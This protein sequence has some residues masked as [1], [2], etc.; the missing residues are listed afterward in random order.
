MHNWQSRRDES[1]QERIKSLKETMFP[2]GKRRVG[3]FHVQARMF[4][5]C[6]F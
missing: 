6:K 1:K 5:R 3:G 4:F 2:Q